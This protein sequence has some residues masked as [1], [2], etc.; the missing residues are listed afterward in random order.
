M[1]DTTGATKIPPKGDLLGVGVTPIRTGALMDGISDAVQSR[2]R[3]TISFLNPNYVIAG[4]RKPRLRKLMNRFDVMLSDGWGVV[5]G[6]RLSG[7]GVPERVANDDI[8]RPLFELAESG[9]FRL[10]LFGS[11]PGIPEAAAERLLEAYPAIQIAGLQH[12]WMDLERGHPGR[13]DEADTAEL[14]RAINASHSD[15]L[16]VGLPTPM[17]QAWVWQNA[18][19]LDVPVM[20]T[21]GSYLDHVAERIDWYPRWVLKWHLCWLYRLGRDPQR[22]WYRYSLEL[23]HFGGLVAIEVARKWLRSLGWSRSPS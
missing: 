2:H 1:S 19:R 15:L 5:W 8:T 12:G 3:L 4:R 11:A 10:F 23:V 6:A 18:V 7:V 22:L 20:M 17:Q 9:G 13:Y 21:C 16:L 14:V